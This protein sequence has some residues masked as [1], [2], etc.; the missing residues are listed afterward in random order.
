MITTHCDICGREIVDTREDKSQITREFYP[1][2]VFLS[3]DYTQECRTLVEHKFVLQLNV[4][5]H[6]LPKQLSGVYMGSVPSHV[7]IKCNLLCLKR[8][9]EHTLEQMPPSD[10]KE[11]KA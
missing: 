8:W 5:F 2:Q 4:F 9:V 7:C 10:S 11:M 1:H 6:G 3:K